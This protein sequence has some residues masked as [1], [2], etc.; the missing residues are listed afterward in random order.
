LLLQ[1]AFV[2]CIVLRGTSTSTSIGSAASYRVAMSYTG[3]KHVLFD[4]YHV[5][6]LTRMTYSVGR[7]IT[8]RT[9]DVLIV[10]F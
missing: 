4:L 6:V 1:L 7:R 5:A 9:S 3:Q 10:F 2:G 8:M